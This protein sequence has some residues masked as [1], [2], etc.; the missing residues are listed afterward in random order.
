MSYRGIVEVKIPS[1]WKTN[2]CP[3]GAR[4]EMPIKFAYDKR[5]VYVCDHCGREHKICVQAAEPFFCSC[6]RLIAI[7][8]QS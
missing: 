3:T 7:G 6:N 1:A 8:E 5:H 4:A 2:F